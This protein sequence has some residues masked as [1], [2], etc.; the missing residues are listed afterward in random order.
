MRKSPILGIVLLI[1]AFALFT[2]VG[3]SKDGK[4]EKKADVVA[5]DNDKKG[6]GDEATVPLD[7]PTDATI[8]GYVKYKGEA[9][10]MKVDDRIMKHKDD[11]AKCMEGG[12]KDE[13]NISEQMWIIGKDNGVD[14]VVISLAPPAGKSFKIP[15]ELKA[16]LKETKHIDQPFCMYVPHVLAV[17]TNQPVIFKNTA[18]VSH[19][20]NLQGGKNGEFVKVIGPGQDTE[21]RSFKYP[22]KEN[23]PINVG[24]NM[25]GWMNAKILVLRDPYFAKTNRDGFFEIKHVPSDAKLTVYMWHEATGRKE[26]RVIETKKGDNE[27]NLEISAQ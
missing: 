19:N 21:P 22:T 6:G 25:H 8:K 14:N 18:N 23:D 20:I 3:C 16:E 17:F 24:C 5:A 26:A 9:P 2:M 11:G 10:K 27:V 12:K 1:P 7:K 13:M 15:D 4:G